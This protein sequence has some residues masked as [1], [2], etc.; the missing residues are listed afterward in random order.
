MSHI[1]QKKGSILW[2]MF[3]KGSILWVLFKKVQ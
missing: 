3:K 2:V 1:I